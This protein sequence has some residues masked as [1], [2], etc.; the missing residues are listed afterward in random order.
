MNRKTLIVNLGVDK[1]AG[2]FMYSMLLCCRSTHNNSA[3]RRR[4]LAYAEKPA[5]DSSNNIAILLN[6]IKTDLSLL[7]DNACILKIKCPNGHSCAISSCYAKNKSVLDD[8]WRLNNLVTTNTQPKTMR[9]TEIYKRKTNWNLLN[10]GINQ[11]YVLQ[12]NLSSSSL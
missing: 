2:G 7:Q 1:W 4:P 5:V 9:E 12:T 10:Y 6:P 11:L 3:K 8:E